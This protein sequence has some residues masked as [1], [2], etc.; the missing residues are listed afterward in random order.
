MRRM[1]V[2]MQ[3]VCQGRK[4]VEWF[5]HGC[6]ESMD[7]YGICVEPW[8]CGGGGGY[9]MTSLLTGLWQVQPLSFTFQL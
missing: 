1:H 8:F 5:S 7:V 3:Q 4:P 9:L 6:A 2:G